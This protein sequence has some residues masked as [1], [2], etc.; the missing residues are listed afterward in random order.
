MAFNGQAM[1]RWELPYEYNECIHWQLNAAR[2][3]RE[4]SRKDG[5]LG[6]GSLSDSRFSRSPVSIGTASSALIQP[7]PSIATV[8]AQAKAATL[9]APAGSCLALWNFS[10]CAI[11]ALF[12]GLLHV[13]LRR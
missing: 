10:I 7:Q 2:Q 12:R 9:D 8:L 6:L 4:L 13:V 1:P 11:K 5:L 3:G